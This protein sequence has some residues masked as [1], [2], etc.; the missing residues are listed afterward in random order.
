MADTRTWRIPAVTVRDFELP[1]IAKQFEFEFIANQTG[2]PRT[3]VPGVQVRKEGQ[4]I[5]RKN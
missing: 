1:R 4:N 5:Q 2:V 3:Q